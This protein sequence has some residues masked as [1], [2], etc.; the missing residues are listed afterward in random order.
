MSSPLSEVYQNRSD[1]FLF[2]SHA[3]IIEYETKSGDRGRLPHHMKARVI[4]AAVF[5]VCVVGTANSRRVK[6]RLDEFCEMILLT[7]SRNC[8][9]FNGYGN[10]CGFGGSG[11]TADAIDECCKTHDTCYF[12]IHHIKDCE[13]LLMYRI[14]TTEYEWSYREGEIICKK[15]TTLRRHGRFCRKAVLIWQPKSSGPPAINKFKQTAQTLMRRRIMRRLIWVYA[16]C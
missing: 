11:D 9:D 1:P 15:L 3:L 2:L 6:R 16:V 7:T 14:F 5:V 13:T 12:I 4:F 8:T 10:W